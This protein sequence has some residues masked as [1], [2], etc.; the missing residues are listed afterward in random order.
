M[1]KNGKLIAAVAAAA[2][3]V[4]AIIAAVVQTAG[5]NLDV[6]GKQSI[7]SFETILNTIPDN[8]KEDEI[9]GGWSL[10][11]P[12]GSVSF[13]WAKDYSQS[14]L[15]DV[16]LELDAAPFVSA[17]LD[18]DKLPDN[19]AAYDGMLM[20]G[21]KL[22]TE[23]TVNEGEATPL[24]AYE[25]IVNKHRSFINYHMDMDHYGV[26]L[27]DDNMFEWAKNMETNTVKNQNQ[28][29]DIVF[30]LNPEPLIAAGVDPEKV[31]GWVYAPVSVMEGAKTLEVYKFLKPFNLK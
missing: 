30:A 13:I 11:A 20:V 14:P 29:K 3:L 18:T 19:Y 21:T 9:N 27:G 15:H 10:N 12:D 6:V 2:V 4:V 5:G 23:K 24:A 28:D 22:G 17:G 1:N 25:Q 16:M 8:V 7:T 31:E 26:K